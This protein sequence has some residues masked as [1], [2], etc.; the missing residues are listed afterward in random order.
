MIWMSVPLCGP[1]DPWCAASEALRWLTDM[2]GRGCLS[3]A[4]CLKPP[5]IYWIWIP[6]GAV[7]E[8]APNNLNSSGDAYAHLLLRSESGDRHSA[9]LIQVAMQ[10]I[11]PVVVPWLTPWFHDRWPLMCSVSSGFHLLGMEYSSHPSAAWPLFL[12]FLNNQDS[13]F[14]A[15]LFLCPM[16]WIVVNTMYFTWS[17]SESHQLWVWN[18]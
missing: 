18:H 8:S 12:C 4:D 11:Y 1:C 9:L 5:K 6:V 13:P 2:D 16:D 7:W 15:Y 3:N 10:C 17:T 14:Q